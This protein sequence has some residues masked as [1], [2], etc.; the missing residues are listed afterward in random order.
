MCRRINIRSRVRPSVGLSVRPSPVIFRRVLGVSRAVCPALLL[1]LHA[2]EPG[3]F[4]SARVLYDACGSISLL[5][6]PA[7]YNLLYLPSPT[8]LFPPSAL[9]PFPVSFR[10][11]ASF[12]KCSLS[13]RRNAQRFTGVIIEIQDKPL[14]T[15]I[16]PP[17]PPSFFPSLSIFV[18][19]FFF[20]TV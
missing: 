18:T 3:S 10:H 17:P 20:L 4:S 14:P 5:A 11:D 9:Y 19:Q 12:Q 13:K 16:S 6:L 15:P 2:D 8:I 7:S 1:A